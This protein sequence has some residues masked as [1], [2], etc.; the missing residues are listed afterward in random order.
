MKNFNHYG[1]FEKLFIEGIYESFTNARDVGLTFKNKEEFLDGVE[2]DMQENFRNW[3]N[4]GYAYCYE[5]DTND[6][7]RFMMSNAHDLLP[8][9]S[10]VRKLKLPYEFDALDPNGFTEDFFCLITRECIADV[11]R[12]S[13]ILERFFEGEFVLGFKEEYIFSHEFEE[14]TKRTPGSMVFNLVQGLIDRARDAES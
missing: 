8:F 1:V 9:V 2:V 3:L 13:D 4:T 11:I 12:R 5:F 6:C 14:Y 7:D 10:A